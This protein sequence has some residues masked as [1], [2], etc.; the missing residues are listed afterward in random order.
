MIVLKIC[1]DNLNKLKYSKRKSCWYN[2]SGRSY[3]KYIY[4]ESCENC[5]TPFLTKKNGQQ[6]FCSNSCK[7]QKQIPPTIGIKR[8]KTSRL[9]VSKT[10][11]GHKISQ[12]TKDK[13]SKSLFGRFCGENSP[14]WKGGLTAEPYCIV[15]IDPEYKNYIFERDGYRCL[16]P[17]CVHK[18]CRL[19]RHH[20]DYNKKNCNKT[21]LIT[22]CTSCNSKANFDREWHTGWYRAILSKRYNYKYL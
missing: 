11:V 2:N 22:L 14:S 19:G 18:S 3:H 5:H 7:R 8:S 4:K 10:L 16:S 21:N 12:E 1:W 6:R 9:K 13:I 15:W 17:S 20:I